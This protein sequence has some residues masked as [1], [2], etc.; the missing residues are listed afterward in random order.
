MRALQSVLNA[1]G[2]HLKTDG[3]WSATLKSALRQF[4]TA[5]VPSTELQPERPAPTDV[6]GAG[7]ESESELTDGHQSPFE[8]FIGHKPV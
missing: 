6:H 1:Q 7:G 8:R 3:I 2:A 4:L 5:S